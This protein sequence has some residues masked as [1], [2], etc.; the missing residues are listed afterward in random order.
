MLAVGLA[1]VSSG[2]SNPQLVTHWG[3][4]GSS[5]EMWVMTGGKNVA[6]WILTGTFRYNSFSAALTMTVSRASLSYPSGI[7]GFI[8]GLIGQRIFRF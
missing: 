3:V 1:G 4:F 6:N 7:L 5:N 2:T 8:K